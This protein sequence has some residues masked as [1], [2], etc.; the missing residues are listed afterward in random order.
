MLEMVE[1]VKISGWNLRR[2]RLK[3]RM[4]LGGDRNNIIIII[5]AERR[6]LLDIGLPHSHYYHKWD[7]YRLRATVEKFMLDKPNNTGSV[8]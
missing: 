4:I 3:C 7:K 8:T 1:K 2:V 6:P 5:S